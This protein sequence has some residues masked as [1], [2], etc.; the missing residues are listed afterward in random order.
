MEWRPELDS[1]QYATRRKVPLLRVSL[2]QFVE[3]F[4]DTGGVLIARWLDN[5]VEAFAA[6]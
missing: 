3:V 2:Q 5:R 4:Q 1:I 6:I